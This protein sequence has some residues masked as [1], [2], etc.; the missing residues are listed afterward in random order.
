MF[1]LKANTEYA[2]AV[3]CNVAFGVTDEAK[4]S[5]LTDVPPPVLSLA[6]LRSTY[7][8]IQWTLLDTYTNFKIQLGADHNLN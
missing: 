6:S 1:N 4:I 3:S 8:S 2:A 7:A 5:I